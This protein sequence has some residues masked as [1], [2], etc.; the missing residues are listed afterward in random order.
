MFSSSN[1]P[2]SEILVHIPYARKPPINTHADVSRSIIRCLQL[3]PNF[4]Y[5][6]SEG[7]GEFAH[8][9]RLA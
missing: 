1:E 3:H 8:M 5:E 6:S 9:Q 7:S 4:L 2:F